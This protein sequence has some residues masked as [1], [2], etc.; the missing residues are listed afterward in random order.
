MGY[1]SREFDKNK[2]KTSIYKADYAV[3]NTETG[4]LKITQKSFKST[5]ESKYISLKNVE[6]MIVD[7]ILH[8]KGLRCVYVNFKECYSNIYSTF[9]EIGGYSKWGLKYHINKDHLAK[10]EIDENLIS[11]NIKRRKFLWK[12]DVY[13]LVLDFENAPDYFIKEKEEIKFRCSTS[14]FKINEN[15][16]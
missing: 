3:F 1:T 10:Y 16:N 15:E 6:Y 2:S 4:E 11:Y 13:E 12:F 7:N 8:F 5:I 9:S 14:S